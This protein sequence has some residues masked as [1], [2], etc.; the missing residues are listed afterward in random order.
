[1]AQE[2][3]HAYI[4]ST[5]GFYANGP[6]QAGM[7]YE[8]HNKVRG[9]SLS[10]WA[11]SIAANW[12]FGIVKIGGVWERLSYDAGYGTAN[13]ALGGSTTRNFWAISATAPI[14]PGE[15][16]AQYGD[17]GDGSTN[18][19]V[20]VPG[21]QCVNANRV[22]QLA[23]GSQTGASNW[24][25]SYTYALSKRTLAYT[26]FTQTRNDANANYNFNI[27]PYSVTNGSNASGFVVGAV[28]FF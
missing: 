1:V 23:S 10:D 26:G 12:N 28:H 8:A 24:S 3:R 20:V 11:F 15:L 4:L 16:Y 21:A 5:G 14:G 13:L 27:N 7:A 22:G 18:C 25:I 17:A 2:Q 6:F 19:K 9:P